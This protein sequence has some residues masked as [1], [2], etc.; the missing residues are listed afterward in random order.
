LEL[1][2]KAFES[3]ANHKTRLR[4]KIIRGVNQTSKPRG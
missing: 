3:W 1:Y 4:L 2:N